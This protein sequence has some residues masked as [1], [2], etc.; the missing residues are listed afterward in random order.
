MKVNLTSSKPSRDYLFS[1]LRGFAYE[2]NKHVCHHLIDGFRSGGRR[3]SI[4][5]RFW[6]ILR[7]QLHALSIEII[8]KL[9]NDCQTEIHSSSDACTR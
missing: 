7:N 8:T 9:R 2:T 5:G 4:I 1:C 3:P 6:C